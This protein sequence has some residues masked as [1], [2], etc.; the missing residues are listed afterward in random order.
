MMVLVI[1]ELQKE[2]DGVPTV[3]AEVCV[4]LPWLMDFIEYG[5]S[6]IVSFRIERNTTN[7]TKV[8]EMNLSFVESL[9]KLRVE[10]DP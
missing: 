8:Q 6:S 3:T 9:H 1:A 10:P 4:C 5:Q 7:V 2:V